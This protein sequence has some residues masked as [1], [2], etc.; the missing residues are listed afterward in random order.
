[1]D[2]IIFPGN[3]YNYQKTTKYFPLCYRRKTDV[4]LWVNQSFANLKTLN[5]R[6][7]YRYNTFY[8]VFRDYQYSTEVQQYFHQ[9][10]PIQSTFLWGL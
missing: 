5:S 1:M 9:A 7:K 8:Q 2:F 10:L 4:L 6:K 3:K